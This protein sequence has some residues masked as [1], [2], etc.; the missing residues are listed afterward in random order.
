[1][2]IFISF[3]TIGQFIFSIWDA[4]RI[5]KL[6]GGKKAIKSNKLAWPIDTRNCKRNCQDCGIASLQA[7]KKQ[8]LTTGT[9]C[10]KEHRSMKVLKYLN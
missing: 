6:N 4:N 7:L 2:S 1:M 5:E 10:I 8:G 9:K 3:F